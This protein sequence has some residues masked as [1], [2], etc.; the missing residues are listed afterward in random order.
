MQHHSVLHGRHL[1]IPVSKQAPQFA[2]DPMADGA[3]LLQTLLIR[4]C[5]TEG[6]RVLGAVELR[7]KYLLRCNSLI[8]IGF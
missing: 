5:G 7:Q 3:L 4:V 1:I 8:T 6:R 2:P